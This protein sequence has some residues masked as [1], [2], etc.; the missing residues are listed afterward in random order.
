VPTP[1]SAVMPGAA[2]APGSYKLTPPSGRAPSC[3]AR[4]VNGKQ[5]RNRDGKPVQ[6]KADPSA[7]HRVG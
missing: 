2:V 3:A 4:A 6:S 5:Q 7:L 1:P